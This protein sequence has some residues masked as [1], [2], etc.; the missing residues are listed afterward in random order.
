M[1]KW[2]RDRLIQN[3]IQKMG[4]RIEL[5]L[6]YNILIMYCNNVQIMKNLIANV[7]HK[8]ARMNTL[9]LMIIIIIIIQLLLLYHYII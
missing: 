7:R 9:F 6:V 8:I 2:Q 4:F 5:L 3:G 1:Y